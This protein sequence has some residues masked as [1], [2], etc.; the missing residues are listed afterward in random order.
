MFRLGDIKKWIMQT[1]RK[2]IP[3]WIKVSGKNEPLSRVF[4]F[5][6]GTPID[7]WY[8]E[9]FLEEEK[10]WICGKV[11]EVSEKKY[12]MKFGENV[13]S[14]D[15]LHAVPG[16]QQATMIADLCDRAALPQNV[17]D[18][19]ICVQTFHVIYD[20]ASAL[21]GAFQLLKP[22]GVLLATMPGISQIS[23]YDM[24]RWGDYWRFTEASVRGMLGDVFGAENLDIKVYGNVLTCSAFLYGAG[25]KEL[26]KKVLE[27]NDPD[28]QLLIGVKAQKA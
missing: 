28:Y 23:R 4:G 2:I 22:G 26:K 25:A 12:S 15:V 21:K 10:K 13:D 8:I 18:C 3:F 17:F 20:I 9:R 1:F 7:R 6:R 16:N 5:D 14:I 24:D 27:Y 11:L 19:F